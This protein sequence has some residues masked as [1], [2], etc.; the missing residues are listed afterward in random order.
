MNEWKHPVSRDVH[1]ALIVLLPTGVLENEDRV[2]AVVVKRQTIRLTIAW[3]RLLLDSTKLLCAILSFCSDKDILHGYLLAQGLVD[4]LESFQT[5]QG[6]KIKSTCNISLPF[7]VK[8]DFTEDVLSF[9]NSYV[10]L[11]LLQLSAPERNFVT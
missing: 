3:A 6:E 11:Y 5:I 9:E 8:R 7:E 10:R 4:Y 2:R 1:I